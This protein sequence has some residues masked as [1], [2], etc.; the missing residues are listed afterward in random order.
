LE[1]GARVSRSEVVGLLP[2]GALLGS[3]NEALLASIHAGQVLESRLAGIGGEG[4]R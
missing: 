4:P 2:S 1:A 3:L